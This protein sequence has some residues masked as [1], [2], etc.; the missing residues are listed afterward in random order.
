MTT[1][2]RPNEPLGVVEVAVVVVEV[3]EEVVVEDLDHKEV[4]AEVSE[5]EA[6]EGTEV[7]VEEDNDQE[8][9]EDK[10]ETPTWDLVPFRVERVDS[11][12][13]VVQVILEPRSSET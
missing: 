11:T 13:A 8:D 3:M 5:V 1:L 10:E 2:K 9:L 6:E 7:V 4:E 12:P